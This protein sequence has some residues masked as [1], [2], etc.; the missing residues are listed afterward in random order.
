MHVDF[1]THK[2]RINRLQCVLVRSYYQEVEFRN[3]KT[4]PK[5][6][7]WGGKSDAENVSKQQ[8]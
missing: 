2:V 3:N 8:M 6:L 4:I 5:C 1:V 7:R